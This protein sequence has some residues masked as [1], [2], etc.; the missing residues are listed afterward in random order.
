MQTPQQC[1][2][3][4]DWKVYSPL[5]A[6]GLT[7]HKLQSCFPFLLI[8]SFQR[9]FTTH[10]H[11]HKTGEGEGSCLIPRLGNHS[12]SINDP[13]LHSYYKDISIYSQRTHLEKALF[14]RSTHGWTP[15]LWEQ[16]RA[17]SLHVCLP[18]EDIRLSFLKLGAWVGHLHP[19]LRQPTF[20]PQPWTRS[21]SQSCSGGSH[22]TSLLFPGE[23][24][25]PS[26]TAAMDQYQKRDPKGDRGTERALVIA[27][28]WTGVSDKGC[29][30]PGTQALPEQHL[31][32]DNVVYTCGA[33]SLTW[34]VNSLSETSKEHNIFSYYYHISLRRFVLPIL[35]GV[36]S[37]ILIK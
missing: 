6:S 32:E 13:N 24:K 21:S 14:F 1:I 20:S 26:H 22:R 12:H 17:T 4:Q 37:L 30:I 28:V 23:Q 16:V 10:T 34:T 8:F 19:T 9:S 33:E 3:L 27:L 29:S 7:F 15:R 11:T 5:E 2:S 35:E 31:G 18:T 36:R 25:R